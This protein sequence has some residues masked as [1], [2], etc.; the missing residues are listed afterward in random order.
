[1]LID[2]QIDGQQCQATQNCVRVAPQL[3]EL[4]PDGVSRLRVGQL[5]EVHLELLREAE[6]LCPLSAIAVFVSDGG[7]KQSA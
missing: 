6:D 5:T 2:V 3:F 1:M 4:G 7:P